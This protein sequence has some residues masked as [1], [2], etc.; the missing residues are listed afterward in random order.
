MLP[1][2]H[3]RKDLTQ[4]NGNGGKPCQVHKSRL[5]RRHLQVSGAVRPK[6]WR[7]APRR[8]AP[9]PGRGA[10]QN[11]TDRIGRQETTEIET[12]LAS[13]L[14]CYSPSYRLLLSL[15][16]DP[17]E[18]GICVHDFMLPLQTLVFETNYMNL[19]FQ[20]DLRTC[21]DDLESRKTG[22]KLGRDFTVEIGKRLWG[23]FKPNDRICF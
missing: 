7:G 15:Q 6:A 16:H 14:S 3:A 4:E 10:G 20:Q 13:R 23:K 9:M 2:S 12:Q 18:N 5:D 22:N 17:L 11:S 8:S 21:V 1:L 19:D